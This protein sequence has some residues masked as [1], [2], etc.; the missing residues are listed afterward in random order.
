VDR[1]NKISQT[2]EFNSKDD[3]DSVFFGRNY[4]KIK[5]LVKYKNLILRDCYITFEQLNDLDV[6]EQ[7]LL[8]IKY[9]L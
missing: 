5:D 1:T 7:K 9:L 4:Q 2:E 8:Q 6:L 3:T